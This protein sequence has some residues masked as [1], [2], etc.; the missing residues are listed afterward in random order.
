MLTR[1]SSIKPAHNLHTV[2]KQHGEIGVSTDLI[3]IIREF[4]KLKAFE[5][6]Q[7]L[8]MTVRLIVT[9]VRAMPLGRMHRARVSGQLAG[10]CRFT[11]G[12]IDKEFVT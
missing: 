1:R 2:H 10:F 12:E 7:T 3:S 9:H 11:C 4:L 5:Q 8:A 6:V